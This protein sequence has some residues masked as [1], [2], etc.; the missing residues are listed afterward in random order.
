MSI[1]L[2]KEHSGLQGKELVDIIESTYPYLV[3]NSKYWSK[4]VCGNYPYIGQSLLS[5]YKGKEFT[6]YK[7]ASSSITQMKYTLSRP[8]E[9]SD[10]QLHMVRHDAIHIAKLL[11]IMYESP[12]LKYESLGIQLK[13]DK[14]IFECMLYV[15]PLD[16]YEF[17]E[18]QQHIQGVARGISSKATV[19]FDTTLPKYKHALWLCG[20]EEDNIKSSMERMKDNNYVSSYSIKSEQVVEV[21]FG[22]KV[23]GASNKTNTL[24]H[25]YRTLGNSTVDLQLA[26]EQVC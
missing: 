6:L 21:T 5:A 9:E 17:L 1:Y 14:I 2:R 12:V 22:T 16:E 25:A 26:C 24:R 20:E 11:S 3:S 13:E 18:I 23:L 15:S 19:E 7:L 8:M 4:R 10:K